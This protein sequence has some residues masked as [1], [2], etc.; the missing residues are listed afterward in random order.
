MLKA[1]ILGGTGY[2]GGEVLKVLLEH[3]DTRVAWATSRQKGT[4][5]D[6]H[7]NLMYESIPIIPPEEITA[8]DVVF[9][10][11]PTG[12]S[13]QYVEKL[14]AWGCKVVDLGADY[15]LKDRTLWERTYKMPHPCWDLADE[16]VYGIPEINRALI[17]RAR[18]VANPGCFSSAAIFGVLPFLKANLVDESRIVVDGLSGTAGAGND[19]CRPMHHPEIGGNVVSYNVVG[20]RHTHEMEQVLGP[21]AGGKVVVH[22]TPA[23]IPIV[24]GIHTTCHLF[25]RR[26]VTV[27]DLAD[28]VS[29]C[30]RDEPFVRL[31]ALGK[32]D[33]GAW[34]YRP[35]PWVSTTS[36]TNFCYVGFDCDEERGRIVVFSVLDSIGKGGA[37]AAIQ[38]I[39]LMFGLEETRGLMRRGSHPL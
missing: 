38:N 16:A 37:H 5:G 15:R 19:L 35:Y 9:L 17:R 21:Y 22:F 33:S 3:P 39:N 13:F 24:R 31:W 20:H 32:E 6:Y 4:I 25:P 1:G 36:G 8:C 30:Y 18:L 10:A 27:Q 7:P 28:A 23:Y 14:L 2:M 34:Q 11:L 12:S 29:S 26:P